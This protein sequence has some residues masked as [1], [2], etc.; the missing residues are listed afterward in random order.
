MMTDNKSACMCEPYYEDGFRWPGFIGST[1][2]GILFVGARHNAAGLQKAG[3]NAGRLH[4]FA[5]ALREWRSQPREP[6][7]AKRMQREQ[8]LLDAMRSAYRHSF[9][10]W[11]TKGPFAVFSAIKDQLGTWDD[12]AFVNLARCYMSPT[13]TGDDDAHIKSHAQSWPIDRITKVLKPQI[14]FISKDNAETR[15]STAIERDGDGIPHVVRFS[16]Y[17]TGK[18]DG[19]NYRVWVTR[20]APTWKALLS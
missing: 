17:G 16:N 5:K 2:K 1:Y 19:D 8:Q 7:L 14:V 18:M 10:V 13:R 4:Q 12:V 6:D 11:A 15:G 20:D 3:M 9:P